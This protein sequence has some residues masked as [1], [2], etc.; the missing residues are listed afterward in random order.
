MYVLQTCGSR[1]RA[2][3]SGTRGWRRCSRRGSRS[4]VPS[5]T[6]WPATRSTSPPRTNTGSPPCMQSTWKTR[7]FSKRSEHVHSSTWQGYL[8]LYACI[9]VGLVTWRRHQHALSLAVAPDNTSAQADVMDTVQL[10][11]E[12]SMPVRLRF[13]FTHTHRICLKADT[14]MLPVMEWTHFC[15][16]ILH[17]RRIWNLRKRHCQDWFN[18]T[19]TLTFKWYRRLLFLWTSCSAVIWHRPLY[20]K[21]LDTEII[22][23]YQYSVSCDD[24]VV[25]I[26]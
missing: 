4:S 9:R 24:G 16:S 21:P 13:P 19:V 1:W 25:G 15:S 14:L 17:R 23:Q 20:I 8:Y 7:C 2:L 10:G 3:S 11:E 26:M 5:A 6:S 12:R 22:S 18:L